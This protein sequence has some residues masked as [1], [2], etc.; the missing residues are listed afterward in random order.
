MIRSLVQDWANRKNRQSHSQD[1]FWTC[2]ECDY[3]QEI[4]PISTPLPVTHW[5]SFMASCFFQSP[6][7][8]VCCVVSWWRLWCAL[9][10]PSWTACWVQCVIIDLSRRLHSCFLLLLLL[11]EHLGWTLNCVGLKTKKRPNQ[12]LFPFLQ[13]ILSFP[14]AGGEDDDH[15]GG[16]FCPLLAALSRLPWAVLAA[17]GSVVLIAEVSRKSSKWEGPWELTSE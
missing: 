11:K 16:D 6:E 9:I 17:L 14:L 13:G 5:W 10:H 7:A 15:R 1:T 2:R 8:L 12:S 4:I 3:G